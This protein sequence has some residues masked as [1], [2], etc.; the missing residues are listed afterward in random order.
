MSEI[1]QV[2]IKGHKI[3]LVGLDEVFAEVRSREFA[4]DEDLAAVLVDLVA[5]KNYVLQASR[6][7]YGKAL[8]RE[9]KIAGG[10]RA[11]DVAGEGERA[12]LEVRVYG[13]GCVNCEQLAADTISALSEMNLNADFEH[14]KDIDEIVTIMPAGLPALAI[15]GKIVAAGAVPRRKKI[16]ELL[17]EATE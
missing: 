1:R 2:T 11:E 10:E 3:G 16:M 12:V 17:K 6:E 14:V 5:A 8:L 15:N 7:D 4:S 13:P 9:F